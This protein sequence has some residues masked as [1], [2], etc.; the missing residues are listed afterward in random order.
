MIPLNIEYPSNFKVLLDSWNMKANVWLKECVYKRLAAKGAKPGF[1]SS[2]G[3]FGT[4]AF[5]VCA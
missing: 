1:W 4:S 3:T 2:M 5:W